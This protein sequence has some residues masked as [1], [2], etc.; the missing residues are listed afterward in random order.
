MP[1]SARASSIP[2]LKAP[3][4]RTATAAADPR[5]QIEKIYVKDLSLEI[6]NAPQ[7]F[8]Q[9]PQPQL[10][11][12]IDTGRR[13]FAEGY[14]EVTVSATV[15]AQ[16]RRRTLFL[17]EAVQAGIFS[18][19]TCRSRT[20]S[21]AG[22][23]LP[24]DPLS[25]PAGDDLRPGRPRRLPAGAACPVS[26]EA[27]YMQRHAAAGP[28]PG[29]SQDRNRPVTRV[30]VLGAG[31][32]GTAIAAVLAARLE[33]AL[34]ARDPE[35]AERWPHAPQRALS[36]RHR[37]S[38]PLQVT[39]G[40][41]RAVPARAR[42]GRDPGRRPARRGRAGSAALPLVW[43]CKGFEEGTGLAAAP[44][45]GSVLG[46]GA[47]RRAFRS[48]FAEEV[49]RGLPCALTLAVAPRRLRARGRGARCMAAGCA[50]TTATTSSASRSAAR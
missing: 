12:Q 30:A 17:A 31:A 45:R 1:S 41:S 38:R 5:F 26:F 14:F 37:G 40:L 50:S 8:L 7:V 18:C 3:H 32:W 16:G 46:A 4:E 20:R 13:Q 24:D 10:E 22:H 27:L 34:W 28:G 42:A 2:Y 49:A 6:P 15:T 11:V 44:D 35:Q 33:V 43:L 25:L 29:G 39:R 19:A 47:L 23:R 9:Q 36:A 48:S 21:A